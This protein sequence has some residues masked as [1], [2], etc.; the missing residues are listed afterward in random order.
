MAKRKTKMT[1]EEALKHYTPGE[2]FP[3]SSGP[4]TGAGLPALVKEL[5]NKSL[6]SNPEFKKPVLAVDPV[7]TN[8]KS[9][10]MKTKKRSKKK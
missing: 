1:D 10:V 7:M 2:G 3:P 5:L 4:S 8:R 9:A 6:A